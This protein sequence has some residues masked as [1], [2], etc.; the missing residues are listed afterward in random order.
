[1]R[2]YLNIL[3]GVIATGIIIYTFVAQGARYDIFGIEMS[4]WIYRMIW[5]L[6]AVSSFYRAFS[7]G[8]NATPK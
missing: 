2:K 1:M 3:F 6:I 7:V 5:V 8:K 4:V